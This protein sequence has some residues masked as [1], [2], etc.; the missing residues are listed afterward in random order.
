MFHPKVLV[1]DPRAGRVVPWS[2]WRGWVSAAAMQ[3]L[4][5]NRI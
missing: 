2:S 4:W 5:A 1:T 3:E